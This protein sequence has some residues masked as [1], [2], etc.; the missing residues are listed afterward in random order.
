MKTAIAGTYWFFWVL[1]TMVTGV[2]A[3]YMVSHSIMLGQFFNWYIASDHLDLLRQ[4]YTAFR[5]GSDA[6]K[7][8]DIPLLLDLIFGTL[9]VIMA[10]VVKRHRIIS[11][12]AG[13]ATWW[14][15]VIF[16]GFGVGAAEDA[17]LTSTADSATVQYY[18][19]VNIPA[20]SSFAVIYLI[21]LLLLL[22]IPLLDL[23]GKAR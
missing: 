16:L 6:Y 3:G 20:H 17:V 15:S 5:A 18:H 7:I 21:S 2:L 19:S 14:V 8:Y 9:F 23:R 13:F 4:T 12:L 11:V 10:F 1:T 22:L